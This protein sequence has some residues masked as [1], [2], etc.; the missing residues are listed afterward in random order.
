MPRYF[1]CS[2]PRYM[3]RYICQ[4]DLGRMSPGDNRIAIGTLRRRY[5]ITPRTPVLFV[6]PFDILV[7]IPCRLSIGIG[8][9]CIRLI[10][11]NVRHIFLAISLRALSIS[12]R[13]QTWCLQCTYICE[14]MLVQSLSYHKVQHQRALHAM[15]V[16]TQLR[17]ALLGRIHTQITSICQY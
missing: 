4:Q 1:E 10:F 2:T 5:T 14:H 17:S 13:Y 6:R 16:L 12:H 11:E 9:V 7:S 8:R 15:K 3:G